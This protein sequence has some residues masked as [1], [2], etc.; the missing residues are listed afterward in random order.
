MP[1]LSPAY[2][3]TAR[4]FGSKANA[5]RHTPPSL[6]KRN[7]F[8][9][10]VEAP[11]S[12]SAEGLPRWSELLQQPKVSEHVEP[13]SFRQFIELDLEFRWKRTFQGIYASADI[14]L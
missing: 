3:T 7:S 4:R 9:L 11:F 12:V 6:L 13:D 14:C 8:R 10:K 2:K 1:L 5:I